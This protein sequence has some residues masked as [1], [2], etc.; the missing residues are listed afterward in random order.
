MKKW[1]GGLGKAI[2]EIFNV[3][4]GA[5][6]T[7]DQTLKSIHPIANLSL[8]LGAEINRDMKPGGKPIVNLKK[9]MP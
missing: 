2:V 6:L 4:F 5:I 8:T 3:D 1:L 7:V 9:F